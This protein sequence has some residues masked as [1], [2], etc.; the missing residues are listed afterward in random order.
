MHGVLNVNKPS[1]PTSHDVVA[2][3]R[4]ATG[5]K[6]VGHAGTLDPLASGVLLVCLGHAT[7]IVEYLMDW[8]KSYRATAVFGVETDT[9]DSTGAI[10]RET[11][12][13]YVTRDLI[14][15]IPPRFVGRIEQVP[16]M[17]SAVHH[18]GK[19]LYD[20]AR[21]GKVVEREGREVEIYSIRLI[22]FLP[23]DRPTA[24]LDIDCSKGTYI[25]TLCADIGSGLDCGAHMSALVRTGIGR[26]RVEDALTPDE[27]EDGRL[28]E[29]LHPIDEVL[30][31]IPAAELTVEQA[32]RA[33][34]GTDIPAVQVADLPAVGKPIRL[35]DPEGRL[36][37]I[38]IVRVR[39]GIPML[40]PDKMFCGTPEL[41]WKSPG[42]SIT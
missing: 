25:R 26:F 3:I 33:S 7:R 21:A 41:Q 31:D 40:K 23:S 5:V 1:G 20:L 30:S 29:A 12:A 24:V 17:A 10:I 18:E 42:D 16:P 13:S 4:R 11:D 15:S 6:K 38:G 34:H 37:G 22:D 36:L 28:E 27:L 9:E 14:E 39:E 2:R 19:R 35:H 32:E 8:P